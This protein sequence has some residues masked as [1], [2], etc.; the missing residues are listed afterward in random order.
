MRVPFDFN[1]K[2]VYFHFNERR[3]VFHFY[4]RVR[5]FHVVVLLHYFENCICLLL[6]RDSCRYLFFFLKKDDSFVR[7][8]S[9]KSEFQNFGEVKYDRIYSELFL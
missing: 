4:E 7:L 1:E 5:E 6:D 9:W 8:V 3:V 2:K